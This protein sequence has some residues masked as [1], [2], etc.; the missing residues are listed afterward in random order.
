V[1]TILTLIVSLLCL[2]VQA[3]AGRGVA[4]SGGGAV[5]RA[6]QPVVTQPVIAPQNAQQYLQQ[7]EANP[8][9]QGRVLTP[10][11][12]QQVLTTGWSLYKEATSGGVPASYFQGGAQQGGQG[13]PPQ[14]TASPSTPPTE[15][16]SPDG[17]YAAEVRDG[18]GARKEIW[19]KGP[20]GPA[21][22]LV[23]GTSPVW[24][25]AGDLIAYVPPSGKGF[26]I[27]AASGDLSS[28]KICS[29]EGAISGISFN[30][31]YPFFVNFTVNGKGLTFDTRRGTTTEVVS[32]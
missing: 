10:A 12:Q 27:I 29:V 23:F 28:L 18:L 26:C 32:L 4:V 6:P 2:Q 16:R 25:H 24:S 7:V 3:A 21:K 15:F 19:V 14:N 13:Q 11:E 1:K 8:C 22:R 9:L 30:K 17:K 20:G 5:V 31:I